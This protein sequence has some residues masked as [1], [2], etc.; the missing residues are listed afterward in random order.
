MGGIRGFLRAEIGLF[1]TY[2]CHAVCVCEFPPSF[3][4]FCL[5]VPSIFFVCPF[6]PSFNLHAHTGGEDAD[7]G[8]RDGL[9]HDQVFEKTWVCWAATQPAGRPACAAF[10]VSA[11]ALA[12]VDA[13][14][15]DTLSHVAAHMSAL[16][17]EKKTGA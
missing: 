3:I 10:C 5:R 11:W 7:A 6:P 16:A 4:F 2:Q 14:V 12:L 15:L 9:V 17:Q 13:V 1:A 8:P